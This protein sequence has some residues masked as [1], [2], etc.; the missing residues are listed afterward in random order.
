[1][2]ATSPLTSNTAQPGMSP[3]TG[4]MIANHSDW[5][6]A[7]V[8][9]WASKWAHGDFSVPNGWVSAQFGEPDRADYVPGQT[10]QNISPRTLLAFTRYAQA[11]KPG[12]DA[13]VD[14]LMPFTP[15][16]PNDYIEDPVTTS[17]RIAQDNWNRTFDQKIKSDAAANGLTARGQD[18]QSEGQI[19]QAKAQ[20]AAA[21]NSAFQNELSKYAT[22]A[23]M[24]KHQE[25]LKQQGFAT[26]AGMYNTN[27]G[28][29]SANLQHAGSL[30]GALQQAYDARTNNAIKLTADPGNFIERE[31]AV[32]ALGAPGYTNVQGY[33]N[34]DAL[35]EVIKKLINYQPGAQP[36]QPAAGTM[37]MPGA[38]NTSSFQL[39]PGLQDI[40][41][42]LTNAKAM[43]PAAGTP[44]AT[45][46][47]GTPVVGAPTAVNHVTGAAPP[48]AAATAVTPKAVLPG[49][50]KAPLTDGMGHTWDEAQQSWTND[51]DGSLN[52]G[53][54]HSWDSGIQGWKNDNDGT[55]Y[56]ATG[57]AGVTDRQFIAGDP[58]ANGRPNPEMIQIHN[59]GPRTTA[60]IT[61]L[62][63]AVR[64]FAYGDAPN[65]NL[66]SYSDDAYQ[67]YPTLKYF[68]GRMPGSSYDTLNTGHATGAFG[69]QLPESGAINYGRFLNIQKDPLSLAL[70]TS[71][72]RS[73]SR[74]LLSEVARAK[75]RAPFGQAV[76]TSLIR[77]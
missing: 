35:D 5:V 68:D 76:Q 66:R 50:T 55:P 21:F 52:D 37:A 12:T 1:M 67:N 11:Y 17:S 27:E 34:V 72:Y 57:G 65:V 29:R 8:N 32:R 61:P 40:I 14:Q 63:G 71:S 62:Q 56:Y 75:A 22:Q 45:S 31:S 49:V 38:P 58:Q 69:A 42:Q 10:V 20:A 15:P 4:G 48:V 3:N 60:S 73:G 53:K 44:A 39:P 16:G 28:N 59:P 23:E 43:P 74:D 25:G 64:A 36:V 2:V 6:D 47:V 13:A 24:F 33:K 54:G 70:L 18:I 19:L 26:Q 7:F 9:Y 77:T 41:N 30:A 46:T 51:T